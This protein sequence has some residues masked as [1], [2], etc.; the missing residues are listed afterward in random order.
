MNI[1]SALRN[2][3]LILQQDPLAYRKFGVYWWPIKALLKQAG[4]TRD[5]LYILGDYMEPGAEALIES[6]SVE[7]TLRAA[8]EEY[9]QSHATGILESETKD[10]ETYRCHDLDA[11]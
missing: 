6:A 1:K 10:G 11:A 8:F 4:Y 3:L 2:V 5:N 7:Q 9:N